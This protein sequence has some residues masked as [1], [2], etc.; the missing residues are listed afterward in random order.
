MS[1]D[2]YNSFCP[3][4]KACEI[5]EPRWTLLILSELSHGARRFNEIRRGVPGIS[6]TLLSKRL[7]EMEHHGLVRRTGFEA[8]EPGYATTPMADE[9]EPVVQALGKWAH[10]NIDR[11]ISLEKLDAGLLMWNMR[12]KIDANVLPRGRTTVIQFTYPELAQEER[13]YWLVARPGRPVDL[14]LLDP[15]HDVDLFIRADLKA[16]TSAWMGWTSL[17]SE[18]HA[19]KIALIGDRRLIASLERWMVRSSYAAAAAQRAVA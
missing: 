3:V 18:I 7:K 16:M 11:E 19:N 5:I 14:C 10:R 6:P 1:S 17:S 12:R 9:L 13:H 15:G 8:G 4:A 2:S